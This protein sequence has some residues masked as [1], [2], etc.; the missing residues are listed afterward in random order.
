VLAAAALLHVGIAALMG[1]QLFAFVALCGHAAFV[2][3]RWWLGLAVRVRAASSATARWS[4]GV[5]AIDRSTPSLP[6][7]GRS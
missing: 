5:V 3:D 2:P 6:S 7:R 4:A 1:L